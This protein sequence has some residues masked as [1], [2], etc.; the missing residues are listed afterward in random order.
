MFGRIM[1]KNPPKL[2]RQQSTYSKFLET[3]KQGFK[4]IIKFKNT[5]RYIRV[6][7]LK[8]KIEKKS[9]GE[10]KKHQH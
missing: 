2:V 6:S 3:S 4:K 5:P 10:Q 1:V 9:G 7:L 8:T